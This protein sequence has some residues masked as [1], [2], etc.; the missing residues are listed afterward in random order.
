MFALKFVYILKRFKLKVCNE[1]INKKFC[2]IL[3]K[4]QIK[5][6]LSI[7]RCYDKY[8][9]VNM[10]PNVQLRKIE[11]GRGSVDPL[12]IILGSTYERKLVNFIAIF[13]IY[14]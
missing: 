12:E 7:M 10:P 8:T 11:H 13:G 14:S 3:L 1:R 2:P 5:N 4:S 9:R 6:I